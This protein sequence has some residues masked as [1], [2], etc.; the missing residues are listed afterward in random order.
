M[1]WLL[2]CS[3]SGDRWLLLLLLRGFGRKMPSFR[4]EDGRRP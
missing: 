4:A 1:E 2:A 3:S